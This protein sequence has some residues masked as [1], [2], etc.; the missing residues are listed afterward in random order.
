MAFQLPELPYRKNALEP[1]ISAETLDY[2]HGKHHQGY[3]NKTNKLVQETEY[4]GMELEDII[5]QAPAGTL[6]NNAAQ[7]W[8]HTFY[9]HCMRPEGGGEPSGKIAD[10]IHEQF[11]SFEAFRDQ[12]TQSATTHF[13]SGW[14]WLVLNGDQLEVYSTPNADNPISE[15]KT[16]L[17]TCD[18]WE[19]A[20]YIDTRNDKG[21]YV[22]NF[23]QLV[24]WE[25][26]NNQYQG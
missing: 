2:H 8:N 7:V 15:G 9:W 3:V 20:Y 4:E 10:A 24:N 17:L 1:Y 18:V 13:G 14:T 19:H 16:P 25:F 6:Y 26:V 12:F 11:G 23:W 21:K 5:K 22:N